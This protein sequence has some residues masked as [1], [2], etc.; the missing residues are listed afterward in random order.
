[1][2]CRALSAWYVALASL[3][4]VCAAGELTVGFKAYSELL[5]SRAPGDRSMAAH[6]GLARLWE[7]GFGGHLPRLLDLTHVAG[8][9]LLISIGLVAL[10]MLRAFRLRIESA[11]GAGR[12]AD[13]YLLGPA[14]ATLGGAAG[15]LATAGDRL[16][17][18][19]A[20]LAGAVTRINTELSG[21]LAGAAD[22]LAAAG[23][24][25]ADRIAASGVQAA[26]DIGSVYQEAVAY[27]AA[28]LIETMAAVSAQLTV[29]V[30][31]VRAAAERLT[32]SGE[33]LTTAVSRLG[34]LMA[35]ERRTASGGP[36]AEYPRPSTEP[37]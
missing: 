18:S 21:Q 9:T 5:A 19:A 1:V 24:D 13:Q 3:L 11:A 28:D 30:G 17:E 12:L 36:D 32:A 23:G 10:A 25:F 2:T 15:R 27:A 37:A 22:G 8:Y 14:V 20:A 4:A 16:E 31:D 7:N 33:S 6:Q 34:G 26:R 35:D 29:A